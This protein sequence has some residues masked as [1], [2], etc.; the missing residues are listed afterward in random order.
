MTDR[1]T[2]LKTLPSNNSEHA[3]N[4]GMLISFPDCTK[5]DDCTGWQNMTLTLVRPW[6][7]QYSYFIQLASTRML[8]PGRDPGFPINP[9]FGK[10]GR[11]IGWH[12][13]PSPTP[14]LWDWHPFWKILD[15]PL[16]TYT[17][18]CIFMFTLCSVKLTVLENSVFSSTLAWSP[19]A[20]RSYQ[21]KSDFLNYLPWL[22]SDILEE[23]KSRKNFYSIFKN[24]FPQQPSHFSLSKANLTIIMTS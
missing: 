20:S 19:M 13:P 15:P 2:R 6:P 16:G 9:I 21:F 10:F 12:P 8:G 22:A 17:E 24:C 1:Q 11:K 5:S 4:N 23:Q 7:S 14:R 18:I 3:L